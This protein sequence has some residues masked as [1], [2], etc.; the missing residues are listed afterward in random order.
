MKIS[1]IEQFDPEVVEVAGGRH[2]FYATMLVQLERCPTCSRPMIPAK[3]KRPFPQY[4]FANAEAQARRAGWGQESTA[5]K[6]DEVICTDC[7]RKGLSSF[8]CALCEEERSSDLIQESFGDP[9]EH[10]CSECYSTVSA[11]KWDRARDDL[12][13]KHRYDTTG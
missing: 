5:R 13:Q 7:A 6:D 3:V 1:K 11:E 10:L 2:D 9:P 12:N 8:T 4:V